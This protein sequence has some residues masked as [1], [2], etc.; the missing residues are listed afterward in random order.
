M[1]EYDLTSID[2]EIDAHLF[3]AFTPEND[4]ALKAHTAN[5][6]IG[7]IPAKRLNDCV[8]EEFQLFSYYCKKIQFEDGKSGRLISI[9]GRNVKYTAGKRGLSSP[10][11][12]TT[13][14]LKVYDALRKISM[15]Y[16]EKLSENGVPVRIR[17]NKLEND[18]KAYT[19]EVV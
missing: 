16:G 14:S 4:G 17:M 9:F 1:D 15:V 12:Y 7:N 19:L 18:Q 11:A 6:L 13:T 8:G 3:A 5:V 2:E 10:C